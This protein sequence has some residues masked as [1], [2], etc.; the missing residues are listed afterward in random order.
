ME[1]TLAKYADVTALRLNFALL[2]PTWR[3]RMR[4]PSAR[5]ALLTTSVT[6]ASNVSLVSSVTPRS[7]ILLTCSSSVPATEYLVWTGARLR[8]IVKD[9]HFAGFRVS[10]HLTDHAD[11]WS[12]SRCSDSPSAGEV[13]LRKILTSSAYIRQPDPIS[14]GRSFMNI[15]KRRGAKSDPSGTPEVTGFQS[16]AFP[17]TMTLTSVGQVRDEPVQGKVL[18]MVGLFQFVN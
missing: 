17:S 2:V 16:E 18:Q 1:R 11:S 6:C 8:V 5:L 15:E 4:R 7:F 14:Q 9:L 12:R 3:E 10:P 13:I